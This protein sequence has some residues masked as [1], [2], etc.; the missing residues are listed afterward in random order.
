[1]LALFGYVMHA[2]VPQ[3]TLDNIYNL[4]CSRWSFFHIKK[5]KK[6]KQLW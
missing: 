3:A 6:T 5:K 2:F 4:K 1:M